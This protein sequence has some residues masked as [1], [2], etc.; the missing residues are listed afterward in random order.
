VGVVWISVAGSGGAGVFF[1]LYTY[2]VFKK[3]FLNKR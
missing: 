1:G 3:D 2:D